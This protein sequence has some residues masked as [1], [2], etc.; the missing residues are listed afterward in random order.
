MLKRIKLAAGATVAV[1]VLAG[2]PVAAVALNA[3]DAP[4]A[5]TEQPGPQ[6]GAPSWPP[7][8]GAPQR[9]RAL[10]TPGASGTAAA[11]YTGY[12]A[13]TG[14][15]AVAKVD[16]AT[17]TIISTSIKGDTAEGVAVTP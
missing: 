2:A 12:V 9:L 17:H 5:G 7:S 16:V 8:A 4:A 13:L 11:S 1:A 10:A 6:P 14:S 15:G 3:S